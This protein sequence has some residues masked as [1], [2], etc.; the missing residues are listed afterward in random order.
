VEREG[1][2]DSGTAETDISILETKKQKN[3]TKKQEGTEKKREE[4]GANN[5]R[6]IILLSFPDPPK[7][8]HIT[9]YIFIH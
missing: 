1:Q 3:K 6:T 8:F 2:K 5:S 4:T 7:S 9:N